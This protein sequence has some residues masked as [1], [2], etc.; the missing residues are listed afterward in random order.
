VK[1]DKV[2]T[3]KE[4]KEFYGEFYNARPWAWAQF[5]YF[6]AETGH[7]DI[8]EELWPLITYADF[9]GVGLGRR[10]GNQ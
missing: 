2:L 3:K 9:W 6:D 4:M 8:P 7:P 5:D 10:I 1:P